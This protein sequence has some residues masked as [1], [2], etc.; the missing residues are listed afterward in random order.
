MGNTSIADASKIEHDFVVA[1]NAFNISSEQMARRVMNTY[2]SRDVNR[3]PIGAPPSVGQEVTIVNGSSL[4]D[5]MF[6]KTTFKIHIGRLKEYAKAYFIYHR[7]NPTVERAL[8][9]KSTELAVLAQQTG[10]E[11]DQNLLLFSRN[12]VIERILGAYRN[13][14]SNQ[15]IEGLQVIILSFQELQELSIKPTPEIIKMIKELDQMDLSLYGFEKN[16]FS[17]SFLS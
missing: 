7:N 4:I 12:F 2:C 6:M 8:A 10:I 1:E 17:K 11:E 3:R 16:Y 9:I 14:R 5:K 13:F 15:S